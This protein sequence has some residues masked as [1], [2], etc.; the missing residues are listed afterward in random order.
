MLTRYNPERVDLGEMLSVEDVEDI[1]AIKLLGVIPESKSV[2]KASN[3][4][5]PVILDD[6]SDAGSAYDDAVRRL[7][8]E[9]VPHRFIEKT[10]QGIFKRMFGVR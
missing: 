1:L 9:E 3:Q 10:K 6:E 8:G 4:G 2:L 5:A 7:L